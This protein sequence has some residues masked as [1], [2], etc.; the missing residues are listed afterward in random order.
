MFGHNS[1]VARVLYGGGKSCSLDFKKFGKFEVSVFC[2]WR[3]NWSTCRFF[4]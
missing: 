3:H 1:P 4:G 2:G